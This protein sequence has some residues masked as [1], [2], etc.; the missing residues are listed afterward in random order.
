MK[1]A[2]RSLWPPPVAAVVAAA[3]SAGLPRRSAGAGAVTAEHEA[4][5]ERP[6]RRAHPRGGRVSALGDSMPGRLQE[7]QRVEVVVGWIQRGCDRRRRFPGWI[8]LPQVDFIR[9]VHPGTAAIEE[10]ADMR[11]KR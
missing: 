9:Q 5:T 8:D 4:M 11:A 1:T 10:D 3:Q 7:R 2:R 6:R